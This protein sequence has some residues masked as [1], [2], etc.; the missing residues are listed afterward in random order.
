MPPQKQPRSLIPW[1]YSHEVD[2]FKRQKAEADRYKELTKYIGKYVITSG[3][4]GLSGVWFID[5]AYDRYS[6]IYLSQEGR[7][8]IKAIRKGEFYSFGTGNLEIP[9]ITILREATDAEV[10]LAKIEGVI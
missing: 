10:I 5:K 9:D 4:D 8:P 6:E 2:K 7:V 3:R 1:V